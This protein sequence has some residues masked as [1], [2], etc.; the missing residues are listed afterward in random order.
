MPSEP[1]IPAGCWYKRPATPEPPLP[2]GLA[3]E[4][5]RV[6]PHR[7]HKADWYNAY[8]ER[9]GRGDLDATDLE[10][11][12]QELPEGVYFLAGRKGHRLP[13]AAHP[14]GFARTLARCELLVTRGAAWWV[15]FTPHGP[16]ATVCGLRL[17]T[18]AFAKA[19]ER[20]Q[21][22]QPPETERPERAEEEPDP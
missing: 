14:P 2:Y 12:Q 3:P 17:P 20:L 13:S 4:Q 1:Q 22:I 10:R 15:L 9:V 8:G 21:A 11:L 6:G 5:K 18:L 16:T 7:L 19:R